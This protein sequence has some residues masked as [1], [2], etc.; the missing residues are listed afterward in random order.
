MLFP[1][2]FTVGAPRLNWNNSIPGQPYIVETTRIEKTSRL[3][4]TEQAYKLVFLRSADDLSMQTI[5]ILLNVKL[6]ILS[7]AACLSIPM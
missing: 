7:N 2:I 1:L 4:K 5:A 3:K 6:S